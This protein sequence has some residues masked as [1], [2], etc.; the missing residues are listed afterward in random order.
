MQSLTE[1]QDARKVWNR[2]FPLR[3]GDRVRIVRILPR[4]FEYKN[5]I[6]K[7]GVI[8]SISEDL[9]IDI[10]KDGIARWKRMYIVLLDSSFRLAFTEEELE[11]VE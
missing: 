8:T 6:G 4:V 3:E 1:S 9:L 11:K 2:I 7:E 10:E 5:C